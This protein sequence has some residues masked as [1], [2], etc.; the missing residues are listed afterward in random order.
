MTLTID[1]SDLDL[2]DYFDIDREDNISLTEVFM[3]EIRTHLVTRLSYSSECAKIV[4]SALHDPIRE[5]AREYINNGAFEE[6]VK[7]CI[8]NKTRYDNLTYYENYLIQV[9]KD[10]DKYISDF[11][12]KLQ[13]DIDRKVKEDMEKV[14]KDFISH[15]FNH[16]NWP[17]FIDKDKVYNKLME[18]FS[19]DESKV[20]TIEKA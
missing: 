18:I 1:L 4:N 10:V 14:I 17:E 11:K 16:S 20:D 3:N 19:T 13:Q 6:A 15:K 7:E 5:A 8:K 12:Q 2:G 9:N